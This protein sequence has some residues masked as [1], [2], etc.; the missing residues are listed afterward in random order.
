MWSTAWYTPPCRFSDFPCPAKFRDEW[1]ECQNSSWRMHS[2][3]WPLPCW[4][5]VPSPR[6]QATA[7]SH[8]TWQITAGHDTRV[9]A[10]DHHWS[11]QIERRG[12]VQKP[13]VN[14]PQPGFRLLATGRSFACR[15]FCRTSFEF[16]WCC[17]NWRG[18]DTDHANRAICSHP[19]TTPLHYPTRGEPELSPPLLSRVARCTAPR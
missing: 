14:S 2:T 13:C 4:I 9:A 3:V 16:A 17:P 18:V 7:L 8:S 19:A 11:H 12:I 15:K 5:I 10:L 1:H 6:C